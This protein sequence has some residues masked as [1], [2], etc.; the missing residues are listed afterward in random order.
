MPRSDIKMIQLADIIASIG[1]L[2]RFPVAINLTKVQERGAAAAW[3]FPIVGMVLAILC[4]TISHVLFA[5]GVPAEIVAGLILALVMIFTGAMHED[6]LAD[7]A[8]GLWGG[9]DKT[10]RLD[11][12][13]DSRIGAYGVLALIM[14]IGLRWMALVT[15]LPIAPWTSLMVAFA[16]SRAAMSFVMA[17]LPNARDGGLSSSVGRPEMPTAWIACGIAAVLSVVLLGWVAIPVLAIA[18]LIVAGC[19]AIAMAKIDGQTGDVLG[20]TQQV[21]EITVL[22]TLTVIFT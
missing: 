10:R 17:A 19:V 21:T 16:L 6:G 5:L 13:K 18:T 9:W 12:M 11:I 20:A 2:T 14:G 3:S 1:L 7:C 22:L 4:A 15:L 8:D